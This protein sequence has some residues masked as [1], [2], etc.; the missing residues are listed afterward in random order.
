[1]GSIILLAFGASVF[2][3]LLACVAIIISRP[4]P[5]LLLMAFY[6]GGLVTSVSTGIAVLALFTN[7]DAVLGSTPSA[8]HPTTSIVAGVIA[9][10]GTWVMA[11][12][13]G[14]AMLARWHSNHSHRRK[15][16]RGDGQSWAERTLGR[17]S[18][19]VAFLVG[20]IINLPGP[21]YLLALGEIARGG[22]SAV[23][24]AALILLF[25][26]IMFLLLEVPLVGYLVRPDAT[27]GRV[28]AMSRWLN[29]NGL[30]ITGWLVGLCGV[31]LLVQGIAALAG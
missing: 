28:T 9:L 4:A 3:T 22:Y 21:F 10:L 17:A 13:R 25:N 24:Q 16:K 14:N 27:A 6:A 11:S 18:W 8:P 23:Q 1:M 2:P 5:R 29:A 12:A 19:K 30:R 15:P 7:G 20:A 26:A 31:S